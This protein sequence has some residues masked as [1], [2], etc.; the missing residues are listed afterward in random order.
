MLQ[1]H[2][3]GELAGALVERRRP[4]REL[5]GG[6]LQAD[7]LPSVCAAGY[8]AVRIHDELVAERVEQGGLELVRI[9]GL[10]RVAAH[11]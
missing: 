6:E 3:S 4:V 10:I 5:L 11:A 9:G 2:P 8:R 7:G 1:G